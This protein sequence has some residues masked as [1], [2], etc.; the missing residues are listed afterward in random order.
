MKRGPI[1]P[2]KSSCRSEEFLKKKTLCSHVMSSRKKT[3]RA[4]ENI[5]N[6]PKCIH[7]YKNP[8]KA[9]TTASDTSPS[10]NSITTKSIN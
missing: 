7:D 3:L 10:R 2:A 6:A 1:K 4:N 9:S 5:H 8:K